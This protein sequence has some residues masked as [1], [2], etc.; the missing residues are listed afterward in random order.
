[1]GTMCIVGVAQCGPNA[2][3]NKAFINAFS[4]YLRGY[5]AIGINSIIDIHFNFFFRGKYPGRAT[6]WR[7]WPKYNEKQCHAIAMS[8][9]G[10][11]SMHI[12]LDI[13]YIV[14]YIYRTA[15]VK[16]GALK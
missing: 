6:S 9:P 12:Q 16:G 2:D 1:M 8:V 14:Y 15:S 3:K 10:T 11:T 7:V 5:M 4:I 13:H